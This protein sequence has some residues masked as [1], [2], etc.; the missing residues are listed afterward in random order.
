MRAK[1]PQ[2]AIKEAE[3]ALASDPYD[4]GAL[5]QELMA[6]RRSG[7]TGV[8]QGLTARLKAARAENSKNQQKNDRYRLQD[9][10][11]HP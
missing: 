8:I 10:I 3:L 7:D 1:Q 6:R 9:D 2:L 11:P 4:E 5:F